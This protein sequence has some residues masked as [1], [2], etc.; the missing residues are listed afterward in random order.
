MSRRRY[1]WPMRRIAV[2]LVVAVVACGGGDD[3]TSTDADQG[4][5]ELT[6]LP[7]SDGDV[8][9]LEIPD[10]YGSVCCGGKTCN[11]ITFQCE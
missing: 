8:E 6:T 1:T 3:D 10:P 5:D 9:V 2:L 11:G 7:L 4:N